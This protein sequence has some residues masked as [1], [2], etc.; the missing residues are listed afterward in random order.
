MIAR[1]SSRRR[2]PDNDSFPLQMFPPERHT[3]L[4][5]RQGGLISVPKALAS[6]PSLVP[7]NDG[8]DQ[9]MTKLLLKVNIERSLGPVHVVLSAE[10]TVSD[11]IKA[12]TEIY[13]TEKRR[14]LL[15]E[16]DRR[17]FEL[18]YSQFSLESTFSYFSL[19]IITASFLLSRF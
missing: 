16:S 6:L 5:R 4:V 17:T 18:H 14:P 9:K 7:V 15:T 2:S 19:L 11:L 8:T 13:V 3:G 12:A 1:S 10:K